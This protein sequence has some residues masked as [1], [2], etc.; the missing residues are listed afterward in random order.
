MKFSV[1]TLRNTVGIVVAVLAV[2]SVAYYGF[3][4]VPSIRR[5]SAKLSIVERVIDESGPGYSITG[6]YPEITEGMNAAAFNTYITGIVQ[7]EEDDFKQN[8]SEVAVAGGTSTLTVQ[9]TVVATSTDFV[10]VLLYADNFL[11]G[12]A[13]PSHTMVSVNFDLS[14]GRNI[15]L[16]DLFV[17]GADYLNVI[18]DYAASDIADQVKNGTYFSTPEY[19]TQSGGLAA[20]SANFEVFNITMHALILHFQE[21]Q[22]GPYASGPATTTIP[23]NALS[24]VM[25][26]VSPLL[27][28]F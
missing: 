28:L 26:P 19:I 22:V 13:H 8:L 12:M 18:A 3:F 14:R 27:H 20:D 5:S 7:N 21:Y 10:S 23:W 24:F 1:D 25:S 9:G 4:A 6:S 16:G 11:V 2:A 15:A 17:P